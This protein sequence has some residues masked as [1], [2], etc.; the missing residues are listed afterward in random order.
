VYFNV[1][2]NVFFKLIY[3]HFLVSELYLHSTNLWALQ[4][5]NLETL[6]ISNINFYFIKLQN[7]CKV[8]RAVTVKLTPFSDVKH[9][10]L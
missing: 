9:S 2:I 8:T 3:V 7:S 10:I 6:F 1:K 5:L 4:L